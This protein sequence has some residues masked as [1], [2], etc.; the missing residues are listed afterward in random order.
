MLE[1]SAFGPV[2]AVRAPCRPH[3]TWPSSGRRCVC[4]NLVALSTSTRYTT[5]HTH[6]AQQLTTATLHRHVSRQ[7]M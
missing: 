3:V 1:M 4:S 6:Q 5:T 7:L 2:R